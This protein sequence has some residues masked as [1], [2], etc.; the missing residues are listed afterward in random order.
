MGCLSLRIQRQWGS[1]R[2]VVVEAIARGAR[3]NV[4]RNTKSNR[5]SAAT[6][7]A[8]NGANASEEPIRNDASAGTSADAKKD[9]RIYTRVSG[10]ILSLAAFSLSDHSSSNHCARILRECP[11]S[12]RCCISARAEGVVTQARHTALPFR[13]EVCSVRTFRLSV[14]VSRTGTESNP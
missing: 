1:G 6:N 4:R 13:V 5:T 2:N 14:M 3:R 11:D 12:E 10:G 8:G 9:W 7:E